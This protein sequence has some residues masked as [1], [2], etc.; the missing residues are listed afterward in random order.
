MVYSRKERANFCCLEIRPIIDP[1]HAILPGQKPHPCQG[2]HTPHYYHSDRLNQY[3]RSIIP[4]NQPGGPPQLF[5]KRNRQPY[6]VCDNLH[7]RIVRKLGPIDLDLINKEEE[8]LA[9]KSRYNL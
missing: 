7:K 6:K 5:H 9:K 4:N 1:I 3:I 2:N 8:A